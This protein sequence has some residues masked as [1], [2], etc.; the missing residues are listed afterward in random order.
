MG[1]CKAGQVERALE[2]RP[3]FAML[4]QRMVHQRNSLHGPATLNE[5]DRLQNIRAGDMVGTA[6]LCRDGEALFSRGNRILQVARVI[7]KTCRGKQCRYQSKRMKAASSVVHGGGYRLR[8]QFQLTEIKVSKAKPNERKRPDVSA[9][10]EGHRL[11]EFV[12]V[13]RQSLF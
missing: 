6:L 1:L 13:K 2:I 11:A 7:E 9:R 12:F 8:R 5:V 3:G 4:D 10:H